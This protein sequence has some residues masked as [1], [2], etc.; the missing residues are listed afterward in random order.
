[1]SSVP[2]LLFLESRHSPHL[3]QKEEPLMLT[4]LRTAMLSSLTILVLALTGCSL[5][6]ELPQL[7]NQATDAP[8]MPISPDEGVETTFV[9]VIDGDTIAVTPVEG[10]LPATNSAGDERTVRLLGIDTAEMNYG[11]DAA[12]ECGAQAATDHLDELLNEGDTLLLSFDPEA[13][14]VDRFDR[15]LAYVAT[16]E[17]SDLAHIQAEAG[18]A[19][20]WYPSSEPEPVNYSSYHDAADTAQQQ[21]LGAWAH[22][23]QLGR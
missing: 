8:E 11:D 13:D 1:M 5:A 7:P 21:G 4:R 18:Y 3:L 20:A 19:I 2:L 17:I 23:D 12:P 9:R 15:S 10:V 14:A 22:C 16:A 6:E